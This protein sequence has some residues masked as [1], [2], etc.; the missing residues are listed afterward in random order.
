MEIKKALKSKAMKVTGIVL[1]VLLFVSLFIFKPIDRTPY[2]ESDYYTKTLENFPRLTQTSSTSPK[3]SLLVGWAKASLVSSKPTPMAGYG[4]RHGA[5]YEAVHDSIWT[6]AFVFDNGIQRHAYVSLD[7]LIVPM[8]VTQM[9]PRALDSIGFDISDVF[10]TAVHSHSSMGGWGTGIA[11][12]LFAGEYDE[13]VVRFIV[14]SVVEAI[15]K[16]ILNLE[17][18]LMGYSEIQAAGYVSNRLVGDQRGGIDPWIRVLKFVNQSNKSALLAVFAAH[19]TCLTPDFMGLSAD[20]PG[21]LCRNLEEFEQF[22]FAIFSAGAM[23]SM[24]PLIPTLSGWSRAEFIADGLAD[25]ISMVGNFMP[26][27]NETTLQGF[28]IDLHLRESSF[29]ISE[30]IS[31]RP[32]VFEILFGTYPSQITSLRVGEV[33]FVGMPCDFSG[34]LVEPLAKKAR[35]V[36]LH[37]VIT[38]FNGGY[39]GYV[40]KDEWYDLNEYETRVMNWFGPYNGAYFSELIEKVIEVH[41]EANQYSTGISTNK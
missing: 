16:A 9:L 31:L 8:E 34:E 41:A 39:I 36:G 18:T 5:L 32:W 27:R 7:L 13:K 40:T 20:Y 30:N 23:G 28:D 35:E 6:K 25:Q 12:E 19:A 24:A 21:Q 11:G 3:D 2:Q 15:S 22:D 37:L 10:L 26:V 4:I 17:R 33:L 29:K 38:S 1:G 14:Q